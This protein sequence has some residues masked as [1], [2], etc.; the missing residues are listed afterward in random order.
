MTK[1][2]TNIIPIDGGY[3]VVDKEAGQCSTIGAIVFAYQF[4]IIS[5]IIELIGNSSRDIILK[6]MPH[7]GTLDRRQLY[8]VIA[9]IGKRI[10]GVPLIELPNEELDLDAEITKINTPDRYDSINQRY[11]Y[12]EKDLTN[13]VKKAQSKQYSEEDMKNCF[14]AAR[15]FNSLDGPVDI[16]IVLNFKGADNSDL[17]AIWTTPEDYLQSLQ[18]KRPISV[19][20]EYEESFHVGLT[21]N[22]HKEEDGWKMSG[23]EAACFLYEKL[24]IHDTVNNVIHPVNITYNE[25]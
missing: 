8:P 16:D 4:N 25:S 22:P 15:E 11:N 21:G 24:K 7:N 2:Y 3:V 18:T 10:E 1:T 5:T 23:A 17:Q 20:L 14:L 13:L 12:S 6:E 9:S 19:E